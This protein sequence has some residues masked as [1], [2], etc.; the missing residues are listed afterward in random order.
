M[1]VPPDEQNHLLLLDHFS[2]QPTQ[3]ALLLQMWV[4]LNRF[5]YLKSPHHFGI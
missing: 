2:Q 1:K 4:L 3:A 5:L